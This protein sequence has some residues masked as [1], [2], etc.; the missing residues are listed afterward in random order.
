MRSTSWPKSIAPPV[1]AAPVKRYA[2]AA[3]R[4]IADTQRYA[5][6]LLGDGKARSVRPFPGG[7]RPEG[8]KP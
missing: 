3:G 4:Q 7:I 1:F 2:D 6:D 8:G 5:A